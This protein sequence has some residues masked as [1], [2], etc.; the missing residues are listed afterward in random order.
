MT[1]CLVNHHIIGNLV[2]VLVS[3]ECVIMCPAIDKPASCET[4][5]VIR[6]LYNRNM[7]AVE[8]HHESCTAV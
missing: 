2:F 7:S 4:R 1:H 3:T 8:I 6:F 5:A